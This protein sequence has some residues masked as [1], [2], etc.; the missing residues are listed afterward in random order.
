MNETQQTQQTQQ[1]PIVLVWLL[2][3]LLGVTLGC[4]LSA[5]AIYIVCD[6]SPICH[7]LCGVGGITLFVMF[8]LAIPSFP[9]SKD[10]EEEED[11]PGT[12]TTIPEKGTSEA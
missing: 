12:G 7:R 10:D 5:G 1:T 8:I 11:E 9:E 6:W 3:L 2:S 4:F